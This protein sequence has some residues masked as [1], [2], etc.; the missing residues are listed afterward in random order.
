MLS[1]GTIAGTALCLGF[2]LQ[3]LGLSRTTPAITGFITGLYVVLTPVIGSLILKDKLPV[4][5]WGYVAL[6]TIGLAILSISGW[7]VGVG[8]VLVLI[9]TFFYA[10][11]ILFLG[12]WSRDFDAYALT[13][14]QLTTCAVVAAIPALLN[15]FQ[16]PSDLQTW[17]V[18]LFTAI[19]CTVIAFIIQTWSQARISAT[20]VAVILTM[21]VVFAA[22]FSVL[23]GAEPLTW[24]ISIG[25]GCVLIAMLA[26]VQPKISQSTDSLRESSHGR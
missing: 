20:K 1:K 5:A 14:V 10:G 13:F 22:F 9:S 25:G 8:E 11:H 18:V 3:T 6:A 24:R 4:K 19:F 26:I 12:A 7:Q 16:A 21:E 23:F 2:T 15:G 17:G